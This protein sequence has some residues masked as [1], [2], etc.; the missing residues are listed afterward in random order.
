MRAG[1]YTG[2]V[3]QSR[4][5]QGQSKKTGSLCFPFPREFAKK[6]KNPTKSE[7]NLY[8]PEG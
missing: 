5:P 1:L 2:T 4:E 7:L 6:E 8:K 3:A